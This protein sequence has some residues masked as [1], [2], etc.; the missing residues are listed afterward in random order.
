MREIAAMIRTRSIST[1]ALAV[2]LGWALPAQAQSAADFAQMKAQMEAMQAQLDAMKSKVDTLEGQLSQAR[3]EAQGATASAARATEVATKAVESAPKVAWKGAPEFTGKDGW[4]FKP[5]G[6]LQIDAAGVNAPDTI[7]TNSLG[8]GTEFRRAY[9]G[10]EGTMPGGFGY[11]VEADFANSAVDLTD[12]YLT[13]KPKPELTLTLGQHKPFWGLEE[14][15]SDLF[16]SFME[17]AAF[18]SA[19]GFERRV[20]ASAVYAGKTFIVQG[21][22]FADNAADLNNDTNN[23]YSFDGRAVFMPKLGNGQ[24]HIGGSLHHREFKDVS[25]TTR[26]RARPFVHTTDVRLVD[27]KAFSADGETSYGAELAY[28]AGRFHA[29]G[30][31]HWITAHRPGLADPTF[32][33]GYAELGY[34][35]TD[36]ET[37]YKGGVYDRIKPRK[38]V[39]KGGIGALQFNARYD[40]LDLSDGVIVGG[41]QQVAGASVVWIPTDYVRFILNYGHIWIDDAALSAAGDRDYSA[42]AVGVRAQFD[43]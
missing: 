33:G 6:R 4:S 13:Y 30:E 2:S 9:L 24:L 15:T 25:T 42:D 23:S 38:P 16:T 21:G 22:V 10:V 41:R 17:R 8:Y 14:T 7:G 34:M 27:T 11:R 29:T 28:V 26:Y 19:F 3:A 39:G 36:D 20:G 37:A 35:L 32:F 12:L 40:L 5:R 1:F 43:F 18:N 31:G